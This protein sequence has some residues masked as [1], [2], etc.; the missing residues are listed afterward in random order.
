MKAKEIRDLQAQEATTKLR[1]LRNELTHLR[2]RKPVGQV[3]N[4]ARIRTI[5]RDIARI[6]TI[7]VEKQK[8]SA[9]A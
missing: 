2:V 6:E 1:E 5:R 3:E 7:L 4:P 8:A 9:A